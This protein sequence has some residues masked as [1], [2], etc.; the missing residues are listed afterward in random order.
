MDKGAQ[1]HIYLPKI[2]KEPST[3]G[4]QCWQHA[5]SW[6]ITNITVTSVPG[7]WD[8]MLAQRKSPTAPDQT[9]VLCLSNLPLPWAGSGKA[10]KWREDVWKL[11]SRS[12]RWGTEVV[13]GTGSPDWRRLFPHVRGDMV[14]ETRVEATAKLR[15]QLE[16]L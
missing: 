2:G 3:Q 12:E 15:E 16:M 5:R 13:N 10:R 7:H 6:E 4:V 1:E 9:R 14:T 8:I 11:P